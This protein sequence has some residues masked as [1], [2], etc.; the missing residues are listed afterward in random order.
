MVQDFGLLYQIQT[1]GEKLINS[2]IFY[3]E[4]SKTE[5]HVLFLFL[6]IFVVLQI[7]YDAINIHVCIC[8]RACLSI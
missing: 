1:H 6:V 5:L 7:L 8:A 3:S 2:I 4:Y